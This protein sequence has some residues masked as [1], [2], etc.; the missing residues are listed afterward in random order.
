MSSRQNGMSAAYTPAPHTLDHLR[1]VDFVAVVGPTASGKSTLITTAMQRDPS[2]HQVLNN[3]SRAPRPGE[4]AG[5][6]FRFETRSAMEAHIARGEYAQVAPT[7]FGDLYATLASDYSA[8]GI[9]LLPVLADAIPAFRAL[10]FK[11]MRSIFV[12]PPNWDS[13][14]E[15]VALHG[16]SDEQLAKR[17][18]EAR[19]SLQFALADREMS[20]VISRNIPDA[21]SDFLALARGE[22]MNAYLQQDQQ[23]APTIV[24]TLLHILDAQ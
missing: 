1:Q 23:D 6:D 22:P 5:V 4:R 13:W 19:C 21:T 12:L 8:E 18:A 16:F 20:Y 10:P 2:L 9:A 15:R 24:R 3:T 14:Q 17:M 11:S 7:V